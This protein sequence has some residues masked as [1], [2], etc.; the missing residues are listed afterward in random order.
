L[1]VH[2]NGE[3][4]TPS[5]TKLPDI[6]DNENILGETQ[7]TPSN[8]LLY[9]RRK[10]DNSILPPLKIISLAVLVTVITFTLLMLIFK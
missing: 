8:P 4:P 10:G 3:Q 9:N 6:D 5:N 2:K 7:P 1:K